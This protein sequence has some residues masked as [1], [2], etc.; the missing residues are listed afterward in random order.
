VAQRAF[1]LLTRALGDDAEELE[2]GVWYGR[3]EQVATIASQ[4]YSTLITQNSEGEGP[5]IF[6]RAR[7][8]VAKTFG[9]RKFEYSNTAKPGRVDLLF[10]EN[11]SLGN[12]CEVGLYD[13]GG[14]NTVMPVPDTGSNV[15]G[16]SGGGTYLTSKMFVF[17]WGGQICNRAPRHGLFI[18]NAGTINI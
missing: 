9:E 17:E 10:P 14:G 1:V 8:G 18:S 5:Q 15:G 11:W 4:W 13:F 6:D 2:K 3:P 16:T 7:S 12:L